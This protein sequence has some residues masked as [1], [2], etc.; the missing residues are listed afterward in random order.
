MTSTDCRRFIDVRQLCTDFFGVSDTVYIKAE[1]LDFYGADVQAI[2]QAA[3]H[4][5]RKRIYG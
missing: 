3:E 1:G 5:A 2:L 4:E